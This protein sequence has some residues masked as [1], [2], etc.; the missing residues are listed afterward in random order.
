[1]SYS[2]SRWKF[3]DCTIFVTIF[4]HDCSQESVVRPSLRTCGNLQRSLCTWK[5]RWSMSPNG[6]PSSSWEHPCKL[7]MYSLVCFNSIYSVWEM[8][9][10]AQWESVLY[11]SRSCHFQLW[12]YG[13]NHKVIITAGR[14]DRSYMSC[15]CQRQCSPSIRVSLNKNAF[16]TDPNILLK[17]NCF[18]DPSRRCVGDGRCIVEWSFWWFDHSFFLHHGL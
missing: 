8:F 17:N 5:A 7:K 18:S 6:T 10:K 9:S 14:N 11:L 16:G 3:P 1:M 2:I 15:S 12:S 13:H 4:L